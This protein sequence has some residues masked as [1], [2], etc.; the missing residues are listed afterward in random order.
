MGCRTDLLGCPVLQG[1]TFWNRKSFVSGCFVV[2]SS[3]NLTTFNSLRPPRVGPVQNPAN[4]DAAESG[5]KQDGAVT[6]SIEKLPP[7]LQ[8]GAFLFF[9]LRK[10]AQNGVFTVVGLK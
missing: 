4:I 6:L 5:Q 7:L 10:G 3:L 9:S 8:A 1:K 2:N